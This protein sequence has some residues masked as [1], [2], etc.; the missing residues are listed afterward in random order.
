MEEQ[1]NE[2]IYE[3][4]EYIG[5]KLVKKNES[6]TGKWEKLWKLQFQNGKFE[7]NITAFDPTG[8]NSMEIKDLE[9]GETYCVG[10]KISPYEHPEHGTVKA[11]T[12]VYI[13]EKNDM[14]STPNDEFSHMKTNSAPGKVVV[15]QKEIGDFFTAYKAMMTDEGQEMSINHFVGMYLRSKNNLIEII[16][17]IEEVYKG[18]TE[19][20][21]EVIEHEKV[22]KG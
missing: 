1:K 8:K 6:G 11:K 12:M 20:K 22:N 18:F 15:D 19:V 14:V 21:E 16:K 17:P 2:I 9:E 7:Q 4:K 13:G 3:N 5:K 10:F